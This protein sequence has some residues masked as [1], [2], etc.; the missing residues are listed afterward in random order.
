LGDN[1]A[2]LSPTKTSVLAMRYLSKTD[3]QSD[4]PLC[5]TTGVLLC[6]MVV[7]SPGRLQGVAFC[8]WPPNFAVAVANCFR[9]L[10]TDT[11]SVGQA[12]AI[13]LQKSCQVLWFFN[14]AMTLNFGKSVLSTVVQSDT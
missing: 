7:F 8:C 4:N 3:T 6:L 12:Q 2:V 5:S 13:S 10:Q 1:Q 9:V 14:Q 11:A